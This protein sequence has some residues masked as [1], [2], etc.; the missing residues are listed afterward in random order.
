MLSLSS[1]EFI[2]TRVCLM[3]AYVVSITLTGAGQAWI[4]K[5]MG[6]DTAEDAGLLT[7]DPLV[8]F[9][10]VGFLLVAILGFGWGRLLP[11]NVDAIRPPLRVLRLFCAFVGEGILGIILAILSLVGLVLCFGNTMFVLTSSAFYSGHIPFRALTVILTETGYSSLAIII[12]LLVMSCV[13]FN[14]FVGTLNLLLNGFRFI[15]AVSSKNNYDAVRYDSSWMAVYFVI[16]IL[17]GASSLHYIVPLG[18]T[19]IT[20]IILHLLGAMPL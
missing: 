9:D 18:I 12:A 13:I 3:F 6:D 15:V 7:L 19:K 5:K 11:V 16:A 1:F 10:I 8:H 14:T 2:A 4:A 17:F 20:Q